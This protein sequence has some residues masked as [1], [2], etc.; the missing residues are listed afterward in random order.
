MWLLICGPTGT[1]A[2]VGSQRSA[3]MHF[4]DC[5][6]VQLGGYRVDLVFGH[7]IGK[8]HR[9]NERDLDKHF[10]LT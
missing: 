6:V 7:F 3:P 10:G 2:H 4:G 5:R 1:K 9:P 8:P